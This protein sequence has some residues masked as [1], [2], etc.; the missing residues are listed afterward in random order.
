[1]HEELYPPTFGLR[2]Q[3]DRELNQAEDP[4]KETVPVGAAAT[5]EEVVTVQIVDDSC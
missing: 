1:M 3:D 5:V 2:T 4:V